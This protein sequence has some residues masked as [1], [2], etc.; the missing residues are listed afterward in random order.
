MSFPTMAGVRRHSMIDVCGGVGK[1]SKK[2]GAGNH[3]LLQDSS[4]L[5]PGALSGDHVLKDW[6][7]H[8]EDEKTFCHE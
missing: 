7:G 2:G 6:N 8:A 3:R 1:E 5:V 4:R